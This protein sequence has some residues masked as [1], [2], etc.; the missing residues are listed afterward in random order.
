LNLPSIQAGLMLGLSL[1]TTP[2]FAQTQDQLASI[3]GDFV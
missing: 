2:A 1:T 3:T